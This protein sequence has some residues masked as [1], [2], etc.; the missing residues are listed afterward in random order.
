MLSEV[1]SGL[2]IFVDANI[3][4]YHFSGPTEFTEP[5]FNFLL[6][7]E[8]GDLIGYTSTTVLT[9]ILHRLMIIE[10]TEKL[11]IEPKNAI[12]YLKRHP[13][14]VKKLTSHL[15]VPEKIKQMGLNFLTT[16]ADDL[17]ASNEIKKEFGFLTNDSINLSIMKRYNLKNIATNDPDFERIAYIQVWKPSK[18]PLP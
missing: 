10:A 14:E 3:F 2:E 12:R 7:I 9:E 18:M 16:N 13:Q 17:I 15:S 11:D 8:E 1:P 5:C 6:R 4:I